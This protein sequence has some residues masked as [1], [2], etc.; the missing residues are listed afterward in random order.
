MTAKEYMEQA[1]YLDMQINS[2]IEQVRSLNELATRVTTVYSDM[3]LKQK[4]NSTEN[5]SFLT[6]QN[7]PANRLDISSAHYSYWKALCLMLLHIDEHY[8][9]QYGI[10]N[11]RFYQIVVG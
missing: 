1:R 7:L 5:N 8:V 9:V 3:P 4:Y 10:S 6:G 11:H 2:K